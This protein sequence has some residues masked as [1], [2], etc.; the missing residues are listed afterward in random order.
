MLGC[1]SSPP[2]TKL[3]GNLRYSPAGTYQYQVTAT[4][5]SGPQVSST[6][7]LNLIVQ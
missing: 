2:G 5:T 6:V 1:G 4:S 7:T 3:N